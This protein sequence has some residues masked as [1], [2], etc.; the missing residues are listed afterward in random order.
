M[1]DHDD[2][3]VFR[4]WMVLRTLAAR[5]YGMSVRELAED[6][7]VVQQTIRRDFKLF[8][9]LGFK[10]KESK[11]ERGR[12]VYSLSQQEGCPPL[13]FTFEEA[14]ALSLARPFLE[15]LCGTELWEA[16]DCALRKIQATLTERALAHFEKLRTVFH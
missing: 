1:H 6:R 9:S 16:A 10:V 14:V 7:G 15:P 12:K 3:Q 8:I 5:R 2:L 4:Q 11:G 13:T